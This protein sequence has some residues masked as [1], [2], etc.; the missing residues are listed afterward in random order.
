MYLSALR[1][2]TK[3]ATVIV[4]ASM[5]PVGSSQAKDHRGSEVS[6][7]PWE[8]LYS[9]RTHQ[10]RGYKLFDF[11]KKSWK[12]ERGELKSIVGAPRVDLI[13]QRLYTDF[14]LEV[15]WRVSPGGDGGV[16]YRVMED[17]GPAWHS[18]LEYQMVDDEQHADAKAVGGGTGCLFEVAQ[19]KRV[20]PV[21][22]AGHYNLT[23]IRVQRGQVEHWLNGERVLSY[24]LGSADFL[25]CIQRSPFKNLQRYGQEKEGCIGLQHHGDEVAFRRIRIRRLGEIESEMEVRTARSLRR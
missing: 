13:S 2:F 5:L 16:L 9:G 1:H 24:R 14:E 6:V 23:V 15:E 4:C 25:E 20:R 8:T 11:P 18:G 12:I 22:P 21:K 17:E 10:F 19:A 7:G 3:L